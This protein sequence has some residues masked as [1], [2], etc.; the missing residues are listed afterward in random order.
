MNHELRH[1]GGKTE[2]QIRDK[3]VE[4]HRNQYKIYAKL[5]HAD[6]DVDHTFA[7]TPEPEL[8]VGQAEPEPETGKDF[9]KMSLEQL[10]RE[11]EIYKSTRNTI[12]DMGG[13]I[14][15][16]QADIDK[17]QKEMIKFASGAR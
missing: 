14:K 9:S 5:V 2:Q 12:R 10:K 15:S 3:M 16:I 4:V 1:L 13:D 8:V 6:P 11:L 17:I 7:P